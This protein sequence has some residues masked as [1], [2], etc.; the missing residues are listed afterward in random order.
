MEARRPYATQYKQ[1]REDASWW[2]KLA[3]AAGQKLGGG[4]F[5]HYEFTFQAPKPANNSTL[6]PSTSNA[7][8]STIVPQRYNDVPIPGAVTRLSYA[9]VVSQANTSTTRVVA[10]LPRRAGG[11]AVLGSNPQ[12]AV[13]KPRAPVVID[14]T[15]E[16]EIEP[17][18]TQVL[19][20]AQ[21]PAISATTSSA[22]TQSP[23]TRALHPVTRSSAMGSAIGSTEEASDV[24]VVGQTRE[25]IIIDDDDHADN[26]PK[27]IAETR[28]SPERPDLSAM[29]I[30]YGF[31]N[32][33]ILLPPDSDSDEEHPSIG[34][35]Y[36]EDKASP[37]D[38]PDS[39]D[40]DEKEMTEVEQL[41]DW[42]AKLGPAVDRVCRKLP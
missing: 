36:Q 2:Q 19:A 39:E 20:T 18:S 11:N 42:I 17:S 25:V 6:I 16:D 23:R 9:S 3:S 37:L 38:L 1:A 31:N 26:P 5:Q 8:T 35:A 41:L 40:D 21:P 29:D 15:L 32:D 10:P 27:C 14:L 34:P 33:Y 30:S 24:F 7:S 13:P 4:A 28:V 12:T 22:R